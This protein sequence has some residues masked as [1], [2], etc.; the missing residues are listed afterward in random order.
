MSEQVGRWA[1]ILSFLPF[2]SGFISPS[3][4]LATA[5]RART[6]PHDQDN[7]SI[8]PHFPSSTFAGP[9]VWRP[10]ASWA[11]HVTPPSFTPPSRRNLPTLEPVHRSASNDTRH[12]IHKVYKL[13]QYSVVHGQVFLCLSISDSDAPEHLTGNRSPVQGCA[14]GVCRCAADLSHFWLKSDR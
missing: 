14:C 9:F 3:R 10:G 13:F 4:T 8:F 11:V 5:R 12:W 1:L 7:S 2:S 6:H